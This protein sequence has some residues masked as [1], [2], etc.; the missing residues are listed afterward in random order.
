MSG[1]YQA[2]D[3]GCDYWIILGPKMRRF[4]KVGQGKKTLAKRLAR[5]A[6]RVWED[7]V[8]RKKKPAFEACEKHARRTR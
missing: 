1:P 5:F 7:T 3:T 4:C 6:N 2:Y 8:D